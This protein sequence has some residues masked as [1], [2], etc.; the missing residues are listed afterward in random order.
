MIEIEKKDI[1]SNDEYKEVRSERRKELVAYKKNRRI[2]VGPFAT[3]YFE[4]Y[5][6]M[7]YQIQ[8][9]LFVEGAPDG[10]LEDELAAYN[11]LIPQGSE[12]VTTLMFEINDEKI[13]HNFLSSIGN[14]DEFIYMRIGYD[15]IKARYESDIDRTNS[16][17]KTSS[18]HFLHFDF[19]QDQIE[20]FHSNEAKIY[21][22]IEHKNYSHITILNDENINFDDWEELSYNL[23]ESSLNKYKSNVALTILG[24][25]GPISVSYTHLTLPTK[26]IV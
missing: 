20:Q 10:Q 15:K 19:N 14:V 1:L 26:R 24:E 12:L 3:F 2:S 18:V 23:T 8:E 16:K 5:K 7:L 22:V 9:M 13:R 4:S 21:L 6:T 17:G 25:A 11:P